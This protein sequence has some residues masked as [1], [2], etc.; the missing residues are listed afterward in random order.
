MKE[1][2]DSQSDRQTDRQADPGF[3]ESQNTESPA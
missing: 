3:G 1:K 2:D